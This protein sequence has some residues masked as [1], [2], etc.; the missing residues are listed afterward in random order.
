MLEELKKLGLIGI[1]GTAIALDK[2]SEK[3][4]ELV[5]KGKLSVNEGKELTEELIRESKATAK[6]EGADTKE[7]IVEELGLARKEEVEALAARVAALEEQLN[8]VETT[9]EE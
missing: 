9:T 5:E 3:V 2:V 8:G 4:D 6:K 1:G 7:K